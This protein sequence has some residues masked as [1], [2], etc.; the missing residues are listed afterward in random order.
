M[1]YI[2]KSIEKKFDNVYVDIDSVEILHCSTLIPLHLHED[3]NS[4]YEL[5][6]FIEKKLD[7]KLITINDSDDDTKFFIKVF[8][9]RPKQIKKTIYSA[10]YVLLNILTLSYSIICLYYD[11]SI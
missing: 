10:I 2:K 7:C 6:T 8:T 11:R 1:D 3:F 9:N 5:C 4:I